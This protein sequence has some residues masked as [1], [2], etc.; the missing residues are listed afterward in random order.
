MDKND[1]EQWEFPFLANTVEPIIGLVSFKKNGFRCTLEE[2][3]CSYIGSYTRNIWKHCWEEHSWKSTKKG[4]RPR[5]SDITKE[6]QEVP[7][8]TMA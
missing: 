6:I 1:L 5:K 2:W 8:Y 4:G 3:R 7:W